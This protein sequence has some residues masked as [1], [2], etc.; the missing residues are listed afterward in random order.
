MVIVEEGLVLLVSVPSI[1]VNGFQCVN[2]YR[3]TPKVRCQTGIS[4]VLELVVR[5]GYDHKTNPY[6]FGFWTSATVP[7]YLRLGLEYYGP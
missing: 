4:S 3:L 1:S 7:I 2:I 6:S 5:F